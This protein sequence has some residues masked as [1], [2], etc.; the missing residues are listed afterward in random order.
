[1]TTI[2]PEL[3]AILVCPETHQS[4]AL[5]AEAEVARVNER[6]ASGAQRTVAGAEVLEPVDGGLVREDGRVLYPIRQGIPVLLVEEGLVLE[7]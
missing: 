2:D 5:A 3:L 4:L 7:G 1:M 6:I